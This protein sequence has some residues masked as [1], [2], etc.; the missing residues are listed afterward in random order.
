VGAEVV[1][2]ARY[3]GK[4]GNGKA[5]LESNQLIF[6]GD[7]RI[8][9][10]LAGAHVEAKD[11]WLTV[12][13]GGQ[14]AAF[15]LGDRAPKWLQKILSPPTRLAKLGVKPGQKACLVDWTD[16]TFAGELEACLGTAPERLSKGAQL[17]FFA[18]ETTKSLDALPTLKTHLAPGGALWVVRPKGVKTITEKDVLMRGREAGLTD[19]KVVA[20]SPTHTAEKFIVKK[21]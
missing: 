19:V 17:I 21:V 6:R 8:V 9:M 15:E 12:R 18:A 14:T 2:R 20:F 10:S 4:L 13:S 5:Q 3:E 11:G 1:C 16:A 7:F